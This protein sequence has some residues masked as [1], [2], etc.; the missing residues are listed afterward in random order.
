M[1]PVHIGGCEGLLFL[2]TFLIKQRK[3]E[4]FNHERKLSNS[5]LCV[6]PTRRTGTGQCYDRHV[7]D[8]WSQTFKMAKNYS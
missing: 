3:L 2:L 4:D 8:N 7:K 5:S 1:I 6:D